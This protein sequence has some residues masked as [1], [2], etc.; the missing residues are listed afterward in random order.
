[1]TA[2][3]FEMLPIEEVELD[4][5]NPRIRRFL[6]HYQGEP[7]YEQIAL[8]LDVTGQEQGG[9]MQGATTP[10]KLR[11]SIRTSGGIMQPIVV[12][13]H[14]DGRMVC[15]EGN[16]RLFIYRSF[17]EEEVE[18]SWERIPSLVHDALP[19]AGVDAIRLQAHL[20]GPRP[21]D[22]YSKAKYL[23]QLHKQ[24]GTPLDT[25]VSLCGGRKR[26]VATA[27]RAYADMERHFRP[28]FEPG[29]PYDTERF[30]GFVELQAKKIKESIAISG[31]SLDDFAT[32]IKR[33]RINNLAEVRQ[34]PAVLASNKARRVFL[35]KGMKEAVKELDRPDLADELGQA[36]IGQLCRALS[37]SIGTVGLDEIQRLHDNPEDDELRYVYDA[38]EALERF[39]QYVEAEV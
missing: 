16:T 37:E 29:E 15:I 26:E 19:E 23:F 9:E 36:S 2:G 17:V 28:L 7:T 20:V 24:E 38:R 11:N 13:R 8:A 31:Y 22:A 1:M 34:L 3:R 6:E 33:K 27:I 12:N 4:R 18:G 21:W 14:P 5:E 25:L 32:W 35:A 39:I 10:E 30:S